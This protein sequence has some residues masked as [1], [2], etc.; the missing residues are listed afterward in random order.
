MRSLVF[1]I[2]IS[3]LVK[4]ILP[5]FDYLFNYEYIVT[6]LCENRDKPK[7]HCNGSCYLMQSLAEEA[8]NDKQ[9]KKEN[10]A[11]RYS[12]DLLFLEIQHEI[13][14]TSLAARLLKKPVVDCYLS[15]YDYLHYQRNYRPPIV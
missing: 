6:E 11:N 8:Q 5:V 7:L 1:F 14:V 15:A 2:A 4:P 3:F 9:N 13:D 10:L 12:L